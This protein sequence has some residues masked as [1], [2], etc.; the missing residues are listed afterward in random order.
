MKKVILRALIALTLIVGSS[1]ANAELPAVLSAPEIDKATQKELMC[2]ARN[3]Y[4]EA[5]SESFEGKVAVAMVT[6]N[7][8]ESGK[9]P[10]TLCGVIHQKTTITQKV[11]VAEKTTLV[12]KVVCQ[13]SWVCEG[14]RLRTAIG[15]RWDD[16]MYVARMVLLDGYRIPKLEDA[17]YFHATHVQ[18]NW[19]KPKV[20]RIGNHIF[21]RDPA[22]KVQN[23]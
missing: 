10:Q 21:Y 17:L 3:I 1:F 12:Q 23:F 5:G 2:L 8:A 13:F 18:P 14:N 19:G 16:A 15:D 9:F 4:Y 6:L 22:P 7:R 11:V 20:A